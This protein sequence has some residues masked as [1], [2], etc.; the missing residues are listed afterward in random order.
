MLL[1]LTG[2]GVG[3]L[4][5]VD[6]RSH[7]THATQAPVLGCPSAAPQL[8]LLDCPLA[9]SQHWWPGAA[10]L[11]HRWVGA[12]VPLPSPHRSVTLHPPDPQLLLQRA[13]S[14]PRSPGRDV[15][16][17]TPPVVVRSRAQRILCPANATSEPPNRLLT[18]KA[19][20]SCELLGMTRDFTGRQARRSRRGQSAGAPPPGAA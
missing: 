5:C 10:S 15:G 19:T 12:L 7:G 2:T 6:Q 9:A 11:Q 3:D 4:V 14:S 18:K 17:V 8:S 16:P 20:R 1:M 13:A